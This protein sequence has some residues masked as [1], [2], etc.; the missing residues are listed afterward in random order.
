MEEVEQ[1]N[2][3]LKLFEC[4]KGGVASDFRSPIRA[5]RAIRG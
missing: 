3:K 4:I 5:I 2:V 1:I